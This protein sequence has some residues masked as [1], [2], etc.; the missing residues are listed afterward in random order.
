VRFLVFGF[1]P[2]FCVADCDE[3]TDGETETDGKT[4]GQGGGDTD[5]DEIGGK[6]E[7][8]GDT[9][10]EGA[11]G[12]DGKTDGQGFMLGE[13]LASGCVTETDGEAEKIGCVADGKGAHGGCG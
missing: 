2:L 1:V 4:D 12:K 11:I 7:I 13:I 6:T 8:L 10:T 9:D 3:V 5:G